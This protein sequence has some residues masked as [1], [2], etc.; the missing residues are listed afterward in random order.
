MNLQASSD[1]HHKNGGN[2]A[3][4]PETS[5]YDLPFPPLTLQITS[6][7]VVGSKSAT[8]SSKNIF[9]P[10]II[11][12]KVPY[13]RSVSWIQQDIHFSKPFLLC[14]SYDNPKEHTFLKYGYRS[15]LAV[16]QQ[17]AKL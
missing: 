11:Q 6:E 12:K 15:V 5:S 16:L 2:T 8:E 13:Y 1:T 4:I 3:T 9:R 10:N 7:K 17:V 14:I